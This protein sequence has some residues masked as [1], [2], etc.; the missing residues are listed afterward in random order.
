MHFIDYLVGNFDRDECKERLEIFFF[1][2]LWL[3]LNNL[4]NKPGNKYLPWFP[5]CESFFF[6]T[7]KTT[8]KVVLQNRL[9]SET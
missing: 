3:S 2:V 8:D 4:P 6:F 5:T 9:K 1:F 7:A